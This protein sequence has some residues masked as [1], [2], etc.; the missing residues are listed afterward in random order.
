MSDLVENRLLIFSCKGSFGLRLQNL[1]RVM[2]KRE[3][4]ICENKCADQLCSKC[5]FT[6]QLISAVV[7]ATQKAQFLL[8]VYPR[9]Q[10]SSIFLLLC[11]TW[12]EMWNTGFLASRLIYCI[13]FLRFSRENPRCARQLNND[14]LI[15]DLHSSCYIH[16]TVCF[17][18]VY[19]VMKL[20]YSWKSVV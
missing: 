17:K 18:S 10:D 13:H 5:T 8:Y 15:P 2:G 14:S 6:A 4:C 19:F 7:L 1:S 9:L 20:C 11:Q 12:S 16:C 3:F